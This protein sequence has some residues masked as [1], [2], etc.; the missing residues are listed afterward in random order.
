MFTC[1]NQS[2]RAQWKPADVTIKNEGQGDM[3]RCPICNARN[4]VVR[5]TKSDGHVVYKQPRSS[6]G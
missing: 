1:Q 3:F 6:E 4:K 5:S 2:C